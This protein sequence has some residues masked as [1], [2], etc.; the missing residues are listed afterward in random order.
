MFYEYA[1]RLSDRNLITDF[2]LSKFYRNKFRISETVWWLIGFRHRTCIWERSCDHN[3]GVKKRV[4]EITSEIEKNSA[5]KIH[6]WRE[7]GKKERKRRSWLQLKRR[8]KGGAED[9]ACRLFQVIREGLCLRMKRHWRTEDLLTADR[10]SIL[11]Q[12]F[13]S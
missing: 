12:S 10:G 9:V 5:K 8:M 11:V 3:W 7:R 6:I 1:A 13:C 2:D 4:I